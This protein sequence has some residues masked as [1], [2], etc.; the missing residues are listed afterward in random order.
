MSVHKLLA[1]VWLWRLELHITH[2]TS[3]Q[4][5]IHVQCLV[6]VVVKSSNPTPTFFYMFT[7]MQVRLQRCSQYL[8]Y[9]YIYKNNFTIFF[10]K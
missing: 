6:K 1:V 7:Y 4:G 3:K 5:L 9:W 10:T 8:I 2:H